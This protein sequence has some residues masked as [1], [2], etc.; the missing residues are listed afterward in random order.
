MRRGVI[1]GAVLIASGCGGDAVPASAVETRECLRNSEF[2]VEGPQRRAADDTDAPDETLVVRSS[3]PEMAAY[4]GWYDDEARADR[5]A[6]EQIERAQ[7][8]EGSVDR[9]GEMTIIWLQGKATD[10]GEEL[11]RCALE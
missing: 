4:I 2:V 7:Q 10:D 6:A 11:R 5:S 1:L 3:G 8:F 9:Y